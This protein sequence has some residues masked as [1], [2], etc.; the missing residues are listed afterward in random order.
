MSNA[1]GTLARAV[2]RLAVV[3]PP[4]VTAP[5]QSASVRAG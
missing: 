2:A 5:P 1:A 3:F 4:T